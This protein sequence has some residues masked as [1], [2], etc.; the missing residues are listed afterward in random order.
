MLASLLFSLSLVSGLTLQMA[1]AS[2]NANPPAENV[3]VYRLYYGTAT[4]VYTTTID[5][6]APLLSVVVPNLNP[7][8]TY[9][10]A[11]QARTASL[12]SLMSP[13]VVF[14]T[15]Q[16]NP[17]LDSGGNNVIQLRVLS[18]T[19]SL[20]ANGLGQLLWTIT[21]VNKI[22]NITATLNGNAIST[23]NGADSKTL[24]L[25][26]TAGINFNAPAVSGAYTL[27]VSA[28]DVNGCKADTSS[29]TRIINVP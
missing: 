15:P 13:E 29:V 11:L 5:V 3:T 12:N 7:A 28:V 24:D 22:V 21:S 9:Y 8:T 17:C 19:S 10:F 20:A 1:T 25:S 4:G 14:T 2:W 16:P 18:F 27:V 23:I 6:S 26:K